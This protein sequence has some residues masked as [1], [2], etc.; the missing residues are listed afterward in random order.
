MAPRKPPI[1]FVATHRE[2]FDD[3]KAGQI[4]KTL[5]EYFHKRNFPNIKGYPTCDIS[6]LLCILSV[7]MADI[8]QHTGRLQ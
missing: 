6:A 4:L 2:L 5:V 7:V 3:R 8:V 1:F